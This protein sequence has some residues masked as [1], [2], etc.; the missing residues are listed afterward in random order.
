[1]PFAV[2]FDD[3]FAAEFRQLAEDVQDQIRAYALCSLNSVIS[4]DGPGLTR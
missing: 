1:M 3:A 4:W 2:L